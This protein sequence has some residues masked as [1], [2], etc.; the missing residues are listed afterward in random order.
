MARDLELLKRKAAKIS[1]NKSGNSAG[2]S[3]LK[4]KAQG[5]SREKEQDNGAPTISKK[6][7]D[8]KKLK[9]NSRYLHEID[10]AKTAVARDRQLLIEAVRKRREEDALSEEVR[11]KYA[12]SLR[13][14][15]QFVYRENAPARTGA[16]FGANIDTGNMTPQRNIYD[17]VLTTDD[18]EYLKRMR[19]Y[20]KQNSMQST[21]ASPAQNYATDENYPGSVRAEAD[22]KTAIDVAQRTL[23]VQKALG[24]DEG[25]SISANEREA[26]AQRLDALYEETGVQA[27]KDAA[28]RLRSGED[29]KR[30]QMYG[31]ED[32]LANESD[33]AEKRR[34]L[35]TQELEAIAA[36][37]VAAD[38]QREERYYTHMDVSAGYELDK[39]KENGWE[40]NASDWID[41]RSEIENGRPVLGTVKDAVF[42]EDLK[43]YWT[44]DEMSLYYGL[45]DAG[46]EDEAKQYA[47]YFDIGAAKRRNE[48]AARLTAEADMNGAERTAVAVAGQVFKPINA[49]DIIAQNVGK[50]FSG[51]ESF[52]DYR[53]VNAERSNYAGTVADENREIVSDALSQYGTLNDFWEERFGTS[54][55]WIGDFGWDDVYNVGLDVVNSRLNAAI[56]GGLGEILP[57]NATSV[58]GGASM[59]LS[60]ASDAYVDA[61]KNNATDKQAGL[62]AAAT[63][64]AETL[65][66]AIELEGIVRI[67]GRV[68]NGSFRLKDVLLLGLAQVATG[69]VQEGATTG[70]Q[71]AAD[72]Y[73][74]GDNSTFARNT[75][76]YETILVNW[77]IDPNEAHSRAMKMA[78]DDASAEFVNSIVGG[79]V[80][81]GG[82]VAIAGSLYNR[83]AE[84]YRYNKAIGKG[85]NELGNRETLQQMFSEAS[86][87]NV[88]MPKSN[89]GVGRTVSKQMRQ[90]QQANDAERD[91]AV[92]DYYD[93]MKGTFGEDATVIDKANARHDTPELKAVREALLRSAQ[94]RKV[95]GKQQKLLAID[96]SAKKT[97]DAYNKGEIKMSDTAVK[98]AETMDYARAATMIPDIKGV[99]DAIEY[100]STTEDIRRRA[101][102]FGANLTRAEGAGSTVNGENIREINGI[103]KVANGSQDAVVTVTMADGSA[104]DVN[105]NDITWGA[106]ANVEVYEYAAIMKTPE[107]ANQFRMAART[108]NV[109][110]EQLAN[111]MN[112]AYDMGAAGFRNFETVKNSIMTRDLSADVVSLAYRLGV[113]SRTKLVDARIDAASKRFAKAMNRE[114]RQGSVKLDS[115]VDL[116]AMVPEQRKIAEDNIRMA[117]LIGRLLGMN[118]EI[119]ES[120]ADA[121]GNF[122]SEQ[123]MYDAATHTIRLDINAGR[124]NANASFAETAMLR[125]MSHEITHAMQ[126]AT[127]EQYE[128]LR[129]AVLDV[130]QADGSYDLE[131]EIEQRMADAQIIAEA[132][133]IDYELDRDAAIDEIVADACEMMLRDSDA[134]QR[135]MD[136]HPDVAK[137]FIERVREFFENIL[138]AIK[139]IFGGE[140]TE[141][142][143]AVARALEADVK[144]LQQRWSD[145]A[146]ELSQISGRNTAEA[147]VEE[148]GVSEELAEVM[149]DGGYRKP[150]NGMY[151]N[152]TMA[153]W[154]AALKILARDS[155]IDIESD[156]YQ[157]AA[158]LVNM[159]SEFTLTDANVREFVPHGLPGGNPL[160]DNVEYTYT[161]D[162]DASCPRTYEFGAFRDA[163]Q[164]MA[165]RKLTENEARTL[166][167]NLR[168]YGQM[169]PCTYCYV[170]SKRMAL[171]GEYL[172]YLNNRRNIVTGA[173]YAA[174]TKDLPSSVFNHQTGEFAT[175]KGAETW[176]KRY[177]KWRAEGR[178]AYAPTVNEIYEAVTSSQ[179]AVFN[180]LDGEYGG[181][182]N[183]ATD[184]STAR[185][186]KNGRILEGYKD[187]KLP[188]PQKQMLRDMCEHF[189][190]TYREKRSTAAQKE[191][192]QY[193]AQWLNDMQANRPHN[194]R[195][196]DQQADRIDT[197]ALELH[198]EAMNYAKSS[199]Q[200]HEVDQY[201]PYSDQI[202]RVTPAAK[203]DINARGGFRKH[204][205]NDFRLD[206]LV[207]YIQF[208][209]HLAMDK[210]GGFGWFGHTYTKDLVFARVFGKT[211]DRINVSIAMNGD[212]ST[213]IT[214]NG[215]EGADWDGARALR[216]NSDNIGV[217]A[218]VTNNDQ[219]SY[220]LN[221]D[222]ID[223]IIPFHAS[224]I[225]KSIYYDVM[226]W[227]DYTA[228]QSDTLYETPAMREQ[229]EARGIDTGKMTNAQVQA[230]YDEEFDIIRIYQY[231]RN[232]KSGKWLTSKSPVKV[233]L[234]P[235]DQYIGTEAVPGKKYSKEEYD[236]LVRKGAIIPGHRN[237]AKR[238][239]ELC[240]QYGIKPR[241][242]GVQVQT[243][244]GRT[245]D[246]TEHEN[247]V[248]V[249]K[250]TARTDTQQ[251]EIKADFDLGYGMA[252]LQRRS[253]K[254]G[255]NT[256]K[257]HKGIVSDFVDNVLKKNRP[258]GWISATAAISHFYENEDA[259]EEIRSLQ[260][261]GVEG[262]TAAEYRRLSNK[263]P[264]KPKAMDSASV[265]TN[266][267]E[268]VA[269][270]YSTRKVTAA[271]IER[272]SVEQMDDAYM[273]AVENGEADELLMMY[274][275]EVARRHGYN[276]GH[277]YHGTNSFG[278]TEFD[279][280]H[281][282]DKISIFVTDSLATAM[283]YSFAGAIQRLHSDQ[284]LKPEHLR[285]LPLTRLSEMVLE[286]AKG[287][288]DVIKASAEVVDRKQ[289]RKYLAALMDAT[290][291]KLHRA[292]VT[293]EREKYLN[294][295]PQHR[296]LVE[297][298]ERRIKHAMLHASDG[299]MRFAI[300]NNII[301][302]ECRKLL[303]DSSKPNYETYLRGY[304]EEYVRTAR[305]LMNEADAVFMTV[306]YDDAHTD[307]F[308]YTREDIVQQLDPRY[309]RTELGSVYDLYAKTDNLFEV[310]VDGKHWFE[311]DGECIGEPGRKVNTRIVAKYAKD[312][313]YDGVRFV[314]IK[315]SGGARP[316]DETADNIL[317]LFDG[318][319]IKSADPVTY[320]DNGDAIPPSQRFNEA[321]ADI[322]YSMRRPGNIT[323]REILANILADAIQNETEHRI[324]SEYQSKLETL[325]E[326]QE[327]LN[328]A[329][330]TIRELAFKPH[331]ELGEADL[332][333]L[334]EARADAE[335]MANDLARADKELLRLQAM[336][337]IK[338]VLVRAREHIKDRMRDD[339]DQRVRD[340]RLAERMHEGA[341]TARLQ[342]E[343]QQMLNQSREENR[344]ARIRLREDFEQKLADMRARK[345][346]QIMRVRESQE[347]V[348]LRKT[349][350]RKA[351][352]IRKAATNP[353]DARHIPD[354]LV[355][356]AGRLMEMFNADDTFDIGDNLLKRLTNCRDAY[357]KIAKDVNSPDKAYDNYVEALFDNDI[358]GD[359]DELRESIEE[360]LQQQEEEGAP[361]RTP[362]MN[363]RELRLLSHIIDHINFLIRDAGKTF[364]D[365]RNIETG[366]I[367]HEIYTQMYDED[368]GRAKYNPGQSIM[369]RIAN[370]DKAVLRPLNKVA[371]AADSF[372]TGMMTPTYFFRMLGGQLQ[373]LGDD[374]INGETT[375]ALN[376]QKAKQKLAEISD[377]YNHDKWA[378]DGETVTIKPDFGS[379]LTLTREQALCIWATAKRERLSD[380]P[381][382]HLALGGVVMDRDASKP[383]FSGT[384]RKDVTGTP[385]GEADLEQISAFLTNEQ[386]AYADAMV[387]YCSTHMARLGNE[388]STKLQ[389][390]KLFREGG[391]YFP[392]RTPGE[393]LK[394]DVDKSN[395]TALYR[396]EGFT[397]RLRKGAN[398]PV[399]ITDFSDAVAVHIDKM[400]RYNALAVPQFNMLR[401]L[402]YKAEQNASV[403]SLISGYYG[404]DALG[405]I[406]QFLKD[407]H[408]TEKAKGKLARAADKLAGMDK[409][410]A[411]S[412]S[413]SVAVQQPSALTKAMAM[414]DI[415]YFRAPVS[416]QKWFDEAM[417]YSGTAVIKDMGR[418]DTGTGYGAADWLLGRTDNFRL[419]GGTKLEKAGHFIDKASGILAEKA[420]VITWAQIWQA[421]KREQA[422]KTGLDIRSEELKKI[423]GKRFDE[424][425]R[426]TQVYDSVMAKSQVMREP[427]SG[428]YTAFMTEQTVTYNMVADA[429]R[430]G[431]SGN[432]KAALRTILAVVGTI[433]YNN[434]LKG[435]VTGSRDDEDEKA[436]WIER[437]LKNVAS[438]TV[439]D[440]VIFNYMPR[441]RDYWSILLGWDVA[442]PDT[443]IITRGF[444][445][446]ST[447]SN[448][449]KSTDDKL[450]AA[451]HMIG[452]VTP[453]PVGNIWRDLKAANNSFQAIKGAATGDRPFR[454]GW[455]RNIA[456]EALKENTPKPAQ[457]WLYPKTEDRLYKAALEDDA[458]AVAMERRHMMDYE[459][460]DEKQV[461]TK[462][463]SKIKEGYLDGDMDDDQAIHML[464]DYTGMES[465]D[466]YFEVT[467]WGHKRDTGSEWHGKF[468][469]VNDGIAAGDLNATREAIDEV[470]QY[471][472]YDDPAEAY[473]AVSSSITTNNRPL[474]VAATPAE[475]T[476]ME[477]RLIEAYRYNYEKAGKHKGPKGK[478]FDEKGKREDI[479]AWLDD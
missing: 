382:A 116:T 335:K 455:V 426:R 128:Q 292:F 443:S 257:A 153:K 402:N 437:Y 12:P 53:P 218:M 50:L 274:V 275:D 3:A 296:K 196:T 317:V 64:G 194:V 186:D 467:G 311:I 359:F 69:G 456:R 477:N 156:E 227:L 258:V 400:C 253:M 24:I 68:N 252:E 200:A 195:I 278:F 392:F 462:L 271:D 126:A 34:A 300:R 461:N 70:M 436:R 431:L 180:Y 390:V 404:T 1:T 29:I 428:M 226:A 160:R 135:L 245:V 182:E 106:D 396:N 132:R 321:E 174:T 63:F 322:R 386:K 185:T 268:A 255:Y 463:K 349:L 425:V 113:D 262:F 370:S 260:E 266:E 250:E 323:D 173:D 234:L 60:S 453:L 472:G 355:E 176:R 131:A 299:R 423:A 25:D 239:L 360:R 338:N 424:V 221:S 223:M 168:A 35:G 188:V 6:D 391:Y 254:G 439:N 351:N 205:S 353:T 381:T 298:I 159:L 84:N 277:M 276:S 434:L 365:G 47:D 337:P 32:E 310:N 136:M 57:G 81:G 319:H 235:G 62:F 179:A 139:E 363:A 20:I 37:D 265:R 36:M 87:T 229:L 397:K 446:I 219:L 144:K 82:G 444:N 374:L 187:F 356:T 48:Q 141:E 74:L 213:G 178:D 288:L 304:W 238:Y 105:M 452:A 216:K 66:E 192:E 312:N 384:M 290:E 15:Q 435:L 329:R 241:F 45:I 368:T 112:N 138:N 127:P 30:V 111:G 388:T 89:A 93:R 324:V 314:N 16:V 240:K 248:K 214:M 333:A 270:K 39:L 92:L 294:E 114:W 72:M 345:D 175:N 330:E 121:L 470:Y 40:F 26:S 225:P 149:E 41:R 346:A 297:G 125:T 475:R 120:K 183:Y 78:S 466:A 58:I 416:S 421:V 326:T 49:V 193:A 445:L 10:D 164:S 115:S 237:D 98:R 232:K 440:L 379:E 190:I 361:K 369:R 59:G 146:V 343:Y 336:E 99:R 162:M 14:T 362:K 76:A 457:N 460:K 464:I 264:I 340:A 263:Y 474:Y 315:D 67:L 46:R 117:E 459:D 350:V 334:E 177:D 412:G 147:F 217:M 403:K 418:F 158:K 249:L 284:R 357:A 316:T 378:Y 331:S 256:A 251:R 447:I 104:R 172:K 166:I 61:K 80:S 458:D 155:G 289:L 224:G 33:V 31:A 419:K 448:E 140:A 161:F 134:V 109:P 243:K 441:I 119:F 373:K 55:G 383:G 282:E 52:L 372:N 287:S 85:I 77:G 339:Y 79:A 108:A 427:G 377:R 450:Y 220:A 199:S 295:H 341:R 478:P 17:S 318:T 422:A 309:R 171:S 387:E 27:Y 411:V 280:K 96:D 405:Y 394:T 430:E 433:I 308:V 364:I 395:A 207:D 347:S 410:R 406:T 94:G 285:S 236:E 56:A 344:A 44:K 301:T 320:D 465:D 163:V 142:S 233:K 291:E 91:A 398:T 133:G 273:Q 473:S 23:D 150:D 107:L 259:V 429:M 75:K 451:A 2:G 303:K 154:D 468:T 191:L 408:H 11:A 170:E 327:E 143:R 97:L 13:N 231:Q 476:K 129:N 281:S 244:D 8:G 272:M 181:A 210:R 375:F 184:E 203:A 202:L 269:R 18:D 393:F 88:Q 71:Q 197:R 86:G 247:Y 409:R 9:E 432:P 380:T 348:T 54:L 283:S 286:D 306:R 230:A 471:G 222:W 325:L 124:E 204:S 43:L 102:E 342:R 130:L 366:K 19:A 38:K 328:H 165:G 438:G 169:I 267:H 305:R 367:L 42:G 371:D 201:A 189:G 110:I 279:P 122:D 414:V 401:I 51:N 100:G 209:T 148:L 206:N 385:L 454:D 28:D 407:V 215:D 313:G 145:M 479:R 95:S 228:V 208:Y 90:L 246:I 293:A 352:S 469:K 83:Y 242:S 65:G 413:L 152:R 137:S 358:L 332:I 449:N 389:G 417:Q 420:D 21:P 101:S 22:R 73:F 5:S 7:Y 442:R 103:K 415:K 167:E 151:S 4:R 118:V 211:N 261:Q 212:S 157:E 399:L 302:R 123:G 376:R 198:R 354:N 307:N